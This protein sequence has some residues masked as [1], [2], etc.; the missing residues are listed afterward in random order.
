MHK[1]LIVGK[2]NWR[3]PPENG[4]PEVVGSTLHGLDSSSAY[5]KDRGIGLAPIRLTFVNE[6]KTNSDFF[7]QPGYYE[8]QFKTVF[9]G[10]KYQ[11]QVVSGRLVAPA[12]VN[13]IAH[14]N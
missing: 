9:R 12:D 14:G 7:T 13:K 10:G 11:Q 3:I 1:I 8:L 4:K 2:N 5:P 6:N